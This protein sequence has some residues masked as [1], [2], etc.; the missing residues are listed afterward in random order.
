MK[1]FDVMISLYKDIIA[2]DPKNPQYH[3]NLSA[4][5]AELGKRDLAKQEAEEAIRLD[6]S[7][8]E[9]GEAFIKSLGF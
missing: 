4:V 1:K 5:Y 2:S 6:P 9:Q 3:G 7:F 8:K